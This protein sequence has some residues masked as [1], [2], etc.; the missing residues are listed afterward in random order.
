MTMMVLIV[1]TIMMMKSYQ[2]T[3]DDDDEELSAGSGP[4]GAVSEIRVYLS[5]QPLKFGGFVL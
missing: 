1:M 2:L 4:L 3:S 5:K